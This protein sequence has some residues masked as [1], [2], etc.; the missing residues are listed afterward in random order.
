MVQEGTV[1][2]VLFKPCLQHLMIRATRP[3]SLV[4]D[5]YPTPAIPGERELVALVNGSLL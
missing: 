3:I 4:V 1:T 2:G 5:G